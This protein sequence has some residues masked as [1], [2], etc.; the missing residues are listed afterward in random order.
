MT[1]DLEPIPS[2]EMVTK[3]EIGEKLKFVV[4]TLDNGKRAVEID[5]VESLLAIIAKHV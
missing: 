2:I 4:Y 1:D 5:G 3:I